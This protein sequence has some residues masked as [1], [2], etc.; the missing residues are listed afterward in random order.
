MNNIF[1]GS[2]NCYKN[3]DNGMKNDRMKNIMEKEQL[4][5]EATFELRNEKPAMLRAVGKHLGV[6]LHK[7][8]NTGKSLMHL[9]KKSSMAEM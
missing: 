3:K 7:S 1:K 6:K 2:D 9:R 8:P 5:K 4:L